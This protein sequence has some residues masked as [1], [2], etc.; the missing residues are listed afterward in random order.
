MPA[1]LNY[2]KLC[3]LVS[4]PFRIKLG[5]VTGELSPPQ[6]HTSLH[7]TGVR[8]AVR[9][10]KLKNLNI[11]QLPTQKNAGIFGKLENPIDLRNILCIRRSI[12][13][14]KAKYAF[15]NNR[16]FWRSL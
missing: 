11:L 7:Q 9:L 12:E 3:N 8:A 14:A 4:A 15:T 1:P 2:R 6:S 10:E 16:L 13:S 5:A